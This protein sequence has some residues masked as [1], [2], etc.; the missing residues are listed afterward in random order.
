MFYASF[1]KARKSH[2]SYFVFIYFSIIHNRMYYPE[3]KL[4]YS[5]KGLRMTVHS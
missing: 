2:R 3:C 5:G 1:I 4:V